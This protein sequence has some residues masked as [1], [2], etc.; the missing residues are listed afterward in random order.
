[1]GVPFSWNIRSPSDPLSSRTLMTVLLGW[2]PAECSNLCW[3]WFSVTFWY[4]AL[5]TT[6]LTLPSFSLLKEELTLLRRAPNSL[7]SDSLAVFSLCVFSHFLQQILLI[8]LV[9]G[10]RIHPIIRKRI[11][12]FDM[13][14]I[15]EFSGVEII[16]LFKLDFFI[17]IRQ[18]FLFSVERKYPDLFDACKLF[19]SCEN[20]LV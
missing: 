3:A 4:L 10:I 17:L 11:F 8:L 20:T 7:G 14:I 5:A 1:M 9:Q 12:Q 19:C 16:L 6:A 18:L 15:F 13:K 2:L